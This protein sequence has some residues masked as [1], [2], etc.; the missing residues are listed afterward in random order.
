MPWLSALVAVAVVPVKATVVRLSALVGGGAGRS[1][2][3]ISMPLISGFSVRWEKSMLTVPSLVMLN[4]FIVPRL[5]AGVGD[6]VVVVEHG[7]AVDRHVEDTLPGLDVP[8]YLLA[9]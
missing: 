5:I 9:K 2:R 4:A 7:G 6:D 8:E 3:M 1:V